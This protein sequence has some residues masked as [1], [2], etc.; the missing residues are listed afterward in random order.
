MNSTSFTATASNAIERVLPCYPGYAMGGI[1]RTA[2]LE[3]PYLEQ[4]ICDLQAESDRLNKM[5]QE[6]KSNNIESKQKVIIWYNHQI[7]TLGKR[8]K[9]L[10]ELLDKYK[11]E[12]DQKAIYHEHALP[13]D[14]DRS[15]LRNKTLSDESENMHYIV[16]K[17]RE[18]VEKQIEV[19]IDNLTQMRYMP[20]VV[21][22]VN[23]LSSNI[24]NEMQSEKHEIFL[25]GS[26]VTLSRVRVIDPVII[27]KDAILND[28]LLEQNKKYS[29]ITESV[30][31][32]VF[33]GFG[34]RVSTIQKSTSS[35]KHESAEEIASSLDSFSFVSQGAIPITEQANFS[36]WNTYDSW[37]KKIAMEINCGFPIAFK[38]RSLTD[39][40]IENGKL[41]ASML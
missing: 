32:G 40:L 41:E 34:T 9:H 3:V 38:V 8:I 39:I 28:E 36:L 19:F 12:L 1:I 27:R 6:E 14:F 4:Q 30:L 17:D 13:I 37:K 11:T 26:F 18:S 16:I 2:E 22:L 23:R 33:V 21:D 29:V 7:N 5:K 25:L 15:M 24:V 20:S 31:G 35:S 10:Q